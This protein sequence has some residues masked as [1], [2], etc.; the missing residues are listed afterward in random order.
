[1][2]KKPTTKTKVIETIA[3]NYRASISINQLSLKINERYSSSHYPEI[4]KAVHDLVDEGILTLSKIG[5]SLIVT[6]NLENPSLADLLTKIEIEKKYQ[7]FTKYPQFQKV[8]P[9]INFTSKDLHNIHSVSAI[10]AERNIKLNR[11]ELLILLNSTDKFEKG[12]T[13]QSV[14]YVTNEQQLTDESEELVK[15]LQSIGN[16][17]NIRIDYLLLSKSDFLLLLKSDEINQVKEMVPNKLTVF[18]PQLLWMEIIDVMKDGIEINKSK[19]ADS[20]LT[21][22]NPK[23]ISEKDLI[24]N[25]SR[26]GYTEFGTKMV[27]G[28]R[29]SIEYIITSILMGREARRI[30]A[31]PVIVKKNLSR[32]NEELLVFLCRKYNVM[33]TLSD[34]LYAA[35]NNDYYTRKYDIRGK[36]KLYNSSSA[37]HA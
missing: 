1:M 11:I 21:E 19:T 2:D 7:I 10:N 30:E 18:N 4:N 37:E 3:R 34:I 5:R 36:L 28:R 15:G 22:T 8:L 6:L 14:A 16:K 25:L 23:S 32:I 26:F 27:K 9:Q 13:D 17:Y 33:N 12:K 31:I 24:Y 35:T 29:I 20:D